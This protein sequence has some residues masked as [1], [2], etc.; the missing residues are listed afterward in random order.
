M[1]FLSEKY[2]MLLDIQ[3]NADD[4]ENSSDLTDYDGNL[5]EYAISVSR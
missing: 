3:S 1:R 5:T 4:C 2:N